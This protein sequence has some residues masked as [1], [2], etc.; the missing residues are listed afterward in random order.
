MR[1]LSLQKLRKSEKR[2]TYMDCAAWG[3]LATGVLLIG[4]TSKQ[5]PFFFSLNAETGVLLHYK[6]GGHLK[7]FYEQG[8]D[9]SI[10]TSF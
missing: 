2:L 3:R 6:E 4:A 8:Q 5:M 7:K 10:D 1:P 9:R